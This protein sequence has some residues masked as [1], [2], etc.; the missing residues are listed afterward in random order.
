MFYG[1]IIADIFYGKNTMLLSSI[2]DAFFNHFIYVQ[3]KAMAFNSIL[4]LL[5]PAVYSDFV[6]SSLILSGRT[7][8]KFLPEV[9]SREL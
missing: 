1:T 9:S 8:I 3:K 5:G 4:C 7:E 2:S 6:L